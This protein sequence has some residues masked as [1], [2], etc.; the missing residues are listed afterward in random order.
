MKEII[1]KT[2]MVLAGVAGVA[3]ALT[4]ININLIPAFFTLISLG[5]FVVP[6]YWITG[7]AGGIVIY[8]SFKKA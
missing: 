8:H 2:S 1:K 7:I 5:S 4:T 6:F 3:G